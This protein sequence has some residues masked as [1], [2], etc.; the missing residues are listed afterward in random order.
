MED[1]TFLSIRYKIL[2]NTYKLLEVCLNQNLVCRLRAFFDHGQPTVGLG[3]PRRIPRRLSSR[4][5]VLRDTV[6]AVN[7]AKTRINNSC[8]QVG[9]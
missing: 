9:R 1:I 4:H 7:S 3:I 5:M 6:I 8:V 2:V